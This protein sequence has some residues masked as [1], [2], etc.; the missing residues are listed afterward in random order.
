MAKPSAPASSPERPN[1]LLILTDDQGYGDI[2]SHGNPMVD[3]PTMD[4]LADE[5]ARFDRFYVSPLCA[6]TRAALLTGRYHLRTGVWGVTRGQEVMRAAEITVARIF[7]DAGYATGCFGKW[8]NGEHYPHHPNGKGFDEFVGFCAGHWCNYFD[9]ELEHNGAPI[10]TEGFISDFLT[11]AALGFIA[12]NRSRPFLCYLPF[13]APHGPFQV[14]D[15][16]FDKYAAAGLNAKDATVYGMCENVD[17]NIGQLLD[18]LEQLGL[19]NRTIVLF[20][21]DNGPNGQRYNGG[22]RGVKG[23]VHEGGHR[24]PLFVRWPGRIRPG[25]FVTELAAHIDILPTLADLC[26]VPIPGG[27]AL[28]GMSLRPLLEGSAAEWPERTIFTHRAAYDGRECPGPAEGAVRTKTHRCVYTH[29]GYELYDMLADPAETTDLANSRPEILA[30]LSRTYERMFR[31]CTAGQDFTR[32]A[33]PIG[34]EEWPQPVYLQAPLADLAGGVAFRGEHGWSH[35]WLVGWTSTAA[36]A[37]WRIAV[38]REGTYEI[39]IMYTCPEEETGSRL[40]VEVAGAAVEVSVDKAHDPP[41]IS[42]PDRVPRIEVLEKEWGALICPPLFL[43]IGAQRIRV[44]P[45]H[46]SGVA[47]LELK[48]LRLRRVDSRASGRT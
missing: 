22:M 31:D 26:N 42:S 40:R 33:V 1:V 48:A 7:R 35:D 5:G 37:S 13:N 10:R 15:R 44:H 11:D 20:M 43:P 24:V 16:Y 38:S 2:R 47:A 14:P 27:L 39:A 29:R 4:R 6:P 34:V 3:T 17:D 21:T 41:P 36:E 8:H 23:S 46:V 9:T 25:T 45:V 30:E 12:A 19:E 32:M 18:R 28:D